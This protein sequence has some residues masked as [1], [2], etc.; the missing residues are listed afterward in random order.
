MLN[1]IEALEQF[2]HPGWET[3]IFLTCCPCDRDRIKIGTNDPFKI[4]PASKQDSAHIALDILVEDSCLK[5]NFL[6]EMVQWSLMLWTLLQQRVGPL[7]NIKTINIMNSKSWIEIYLA[8][9]DANLFNLYVISWA[10][11]VCDLVLLVLKFSLIKAVV[12]WF[13]SPANIILS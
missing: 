1:N 8:K 7:I 4:P 6:K 10:H 9:V 13:I 5:F 12:M 11:T 3:Q 2:H